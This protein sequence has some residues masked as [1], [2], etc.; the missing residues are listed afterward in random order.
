MAIVIAPFS[1][2]SSELIKMAVGSSAE[3]PIGTI[4]KLAGINTIAVCGAS[5]TPLGVIIA[6]EHNDPAPD[7]FLIA[8]SGI[9]AGVICAS[10]VTAGDE[11]VP[12]AG[13]KAQPLSVSPT[14]YV[15][16]VAIENGVADAVIKVQLNLVIGGGAGGNLQ[17]AYNSGSDVLVNSA[18]GAIDIY[19]PSVL[20]RI[21]A[22]AV[23]DS[24]DTAFGIRSTM[25]NSSGLSERGGVF[26]QY[27]TGS[28][29]TWGSLGYK[30][31]GGAG[32][33][34]GV[35]A[36]DRERV[37]GYLGGASDQAGV[38]GIYQYT[39]GGGM[40][41]YFQNTATGGATQYGARSVTSGAGIV[42]KYGVSG[43]V[44]GGGTTAIGVSG[45]AIGSTTN[46]GLYGTATT[47]TGA[48]TN[49]GVFGFA[50]AASGNNYG[51]Y[52]TTTSIG[53]FGVYG[54][55]TNS[56][57]SGNKF[58][59][60]GVA[61]GG[62]VGS[63]VNY[64]VNGFAAGG[65]V[66]F[67]GY[68][69]PILG[70]A[71]QSDPAPTGP[72]AV[73]AGALYVKSTAS[74]PDTLKFWDDQAGAWIVVAPITT[75]GGGSYWSRNA[76][77]GYLYP[78]TSG[79]RAEVWATSGN[80]AV[81]GYGGSARET[82]PWGSLGTVSR[83]V[84]GQYE[85]TAATPRN[86]GGIGD[87]SGGTG[88]GAYGYGYTEINSG[89]A[90][91][92]HGK[93]TS[94]GATTVYKYGIYGEVPSGTGANIYN[95]GVYGTVPTSAISY[96]VYG[97]AGGS[98]NYGYL[99]SNGTG[100]YGVGSSY[101]VRG[102]RS[103]SGY[104]V[105]GQDGTGTSPTNYGYI[106]DGSNGVYGQYNSAIY[107]ILGCNTGTASGVY[108]SM[109]GA[110]TD[111]NGVFGYADGN[112]SGTTHYKYGVRG[113][114]VGTGAT[115]INYG[116]FG[117]TAN[118]GNQN[119]G[120]YGKY[121]AGT[122]NYGYVGS[123]Q[124]GG[125]GAYGNGDVYGVYGANTNTSIGTISRYAIRGAATGSG[126]SCINYGIYGQASGATNNYS[127]YCDN[128]GYF[129]FP[130][131]TS[132]PAPGSLVD[133]TSFFNTSSGGKLEILNGGSWISFGASGTS[134]WSDMTDYIVSTANPGGE[135]VWVYDDMGS[136]HNQY[137]YVT[138]TNPTDGKQLIKAWDQSTGSVTGGRNN[139][140]YAETGVYTGSSGSWALARS[141]GAILGY[142]NSTTGTYSYGVAGYH[143]GNTANT[144]HAAV[145]GG[146]NFTTTTNVPLTY[147]ALGYQETSLKAQ[148]VY[149]YS[150]WNGSESYGVYGSA[151][152]AATT[153]YGA[154]FT[155]SGGT[156]NYAL[157]L[158]GDFFN[159][160]V[161]AD[162]TN[163]DPGVTWT[164]LKTVT[165]TTHG[166]GATRSTVII[167][168]SATIGTSAAR[169][170]A[171]SGWGNVY[172]RI[173][174]DGT[175][176]MSAMATVGGVDDDGTNTYY[177]GGSAALAIAAYDE[178]TEASHT[179]KLQYSVGILTVF[180][181]TPNA[182]V[183]YEI[184]R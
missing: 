141:S 144:P 69:S 139:A 166:T 36:N 7:S 68:F 114:A 181:T 161:G 52:G 76:I 156:S 82:G 8:S 78:T 16:G 170:L 91:G 152:G 29:S 154:Y 3:I 71:P 112:G 176:I 25:R 131:A 31:S 84:Y 17:Q 126:S 4:V 180:R 110:G 9:T 40:G 107:G 66:N 32:S 136:S 47:G 42:T 63:S 48:T 54:I 140:I 51:I 58:G 97:S 103:T 19:V 50:A 108:G 6:F 44:S 62:G 23:V 90:I 169:L 175:M 118:N 153:N 24:A 124:N 34:Y 122:N 94:A 165:I 177:Y 125:T 28:D 183:V 56:S 171:N 174:R 147:G 115:D 75:G 43:E 65:N 88:K 96:A 100:A 27:K 89:S 119:Y 41:G 79:D 60:S 157:R 160:E 13:G 35:Y 109:T 86:F 45:D 61:N 123:G 67:G 143:Y 159:Q 135:G 120:V 64:G 93:A 158:E 80:G 95:Y 14:G 26:G 5:D 104:G 18:Q 70:I 178:P 102:D 37:I 146:S 127:V 130:T 105:W 59:V 92:V 46:Q 11:L 10:A 117:I 21:S 132:E 74:A 145:F 138:A 53:G 134:L 113:Q 39:T 149:G 121:N 49:Y 151:T 15:I 83:G 2:F 87:Y 172:I 38:G 155:A 150:I 133:G 55:N 99:A 179:Y 142:E 22:I 101:G 57:S 116:V 12:A 173:T 129:R 137:L 148:G 111:A 184:K 81:I 85:A 98:S 72:A 106:A 30:A 77:G 168:A 1:L 33:R 128:S 167:S 164:D 163:Y 73:L 20:N 182:L 162:Q